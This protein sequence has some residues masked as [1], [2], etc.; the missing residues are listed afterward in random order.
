[1]GNKYRDY[2]QMKYIEYDKQLFRVPALDCILIV[3][4]AYAV[5]QKS[6]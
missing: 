1:M 4:H 5:L 2:C 6:L 3:P